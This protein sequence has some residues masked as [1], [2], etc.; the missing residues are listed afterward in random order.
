M[1][2]P[3]NIKIENKKIVIVG[4]GKVAAHKLM[5]IVKFID[6]KQIVVC[7]ESIL[8]EVREL[9]VVCIEQEYS[10]TLLKDAFLVYACTNDVQ[11]NQQVCLDARELG[12]LIN[13]ADNSSLSDFISPAVYKDEHMSVAVSSQGKEVKKSVNWRNKIASFIESLKGQM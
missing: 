5:T 11:V 2:L 9:G 8:T 13:V 6:A 12:A 4:G 3:I 10:K 1:Y 7:A